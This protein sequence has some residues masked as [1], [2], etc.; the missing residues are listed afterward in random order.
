MISN[1]RGNLPGQV[2]GAGADVEI[3]RHKEPGVGDADASTNARYAVHPA[4]GRGDASDAAERGA[5]AERARDCNAQAVIHPGAHRG[6]AEA[7]E[8][9]NVPPGPLQYSI[10]TR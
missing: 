5:V 2:G 4:A 8:Q 3:I 1:A 10:A 7:G 6:E 9:I